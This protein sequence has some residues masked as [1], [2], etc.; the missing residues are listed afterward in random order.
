[1]R[2]M[3]RQRHAWVE[4]DAEID[5]I[6]VHAETNKADG[7]CRPG[8]RTDVFNRLSAGWLPNMAGG[9]A[10]ARSEDL[11]ASPKGE[12]PPTPPRPFRPACSAHSAT[13]PPSPLASATLRHRA[14]LFLAA[15]PVSAYT[16]APR[17][18]ASRPKRTSCSA[19]RIP[20]GMFHTRRP[21]HRSPAS[22]DSRRRCRSRRVPR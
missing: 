7:P 20:H 17:T 10:Q 1:M 12:A 2:C 14:R 8:W 5:T 19:P 22:T 3:Q 21:A 11:R 4:M 18:V 16:F 6:E 13:P 15:S 9:D